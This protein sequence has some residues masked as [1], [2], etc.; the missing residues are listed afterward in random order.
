MAESKKII[1]VAHPNQSAPST[2][3]KSVIITRR[4]VIQDSMVVE[5]GA[6]NTDTQ[7]ETVATR[8]AKVNIQPLTAPELPGK[9]SSKSET[10]T[11]P[12]ETAAETVKNTADST[13]TD[14]S[15][16]AGK[17]VISPLASSVVTT[18]ESEPESEKPDTAAKPTNE[19]SSSSKSTTVPGPTYDKTTLEGDEG[20]I[21]AAAQQ[22][23]IDAE[24]EKADKALQ[25]LID[26]KAYYLPINSLEKRRTKRTA[27]LGFVVSLALIALWIDVALDA[28]LLHING[29]QPLTHLFSS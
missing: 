17:K 1:D 18:P 9:Q 14:A 16:V 24:K 3:S 27:I 11:A 22:D 4:P 6:E 12:D 5:N 13:P 20:P 7:D 25:K 8:P 10:S 23:A 2:N 19:T 26:D 15:P 29:L 28:G 21:S